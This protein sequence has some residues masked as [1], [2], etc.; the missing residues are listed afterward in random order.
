MQRNRPQLSWEL[1]PS[2]IEERAA[3]LAKSIVVISGAQEKPRNITIEMNVSNITTIK[4]W[5]PL[6]YQRCSKHTWLTHMAINKKRA[7]KVLM[8]ISN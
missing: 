4:Y 7:Q 1:P 8:I 2:A 6:W 3:P 5:H